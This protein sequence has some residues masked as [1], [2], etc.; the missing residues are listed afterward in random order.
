MSVFAS[1]MFTAFSDGRTSAIISFARTFGFI[2]ISVL[3]L[4]HFL[5]IDGVW[6]SVPAAEAVTLLLS[7]WFL[8]RYRSKYH[9]A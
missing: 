4:P 9:Y 6:L 1:S 8:R 3:T 7:A 5:G 2:L